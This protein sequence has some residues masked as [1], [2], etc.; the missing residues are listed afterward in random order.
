MSTDK[1][2]SESN[3]SSSFVWVGLAAIVGLLSGF[4]AG[5][6]L[7]RLRKREEPEALPPIEPAEPE[8]I[9]DIAAEP[10][11]SEPVID[12]PMP[13]RWR[14]WLLIPIAVLSWQAHLRLQD[15]DSNGF[16]WLAIA[17]VLIALAIPPISVK[18]L[19]TQHN[20]RVAGLGRQ[21]I[22]A[23][24]LAAG[25]AL[26]L[27][28]ANLFW[29]LEPGV[30]P[31]AAPWNDY[32]VGVA[33]WMAG[34]LV[35]TRSSWRWHWHPALVLLI[36]LIGL[37][38]FLRFYQFEAFPIGVWHDE[39]VNALEAR[40]MLNIPDYEP[41]F[42]PNITG[43]HL[44]LY[45][46]GLE[47]I[48]VTDISG[49]RL[50]SA[51]FGLASVIMAYAVGNQLRGPYFGLLMALMLAVM[52]WSLTF[53]RIAM[54][55]VEVGFFTL[56]TL[57]FVIRLARH[58]ELR[59]A[60]LTGLSLGLGLWFYSAFRLIG[61]PLAVFGLIAWLTWQGRTWRSLL[62]VG[63]TVAFTALVVIFPLVSYADINSE[64]FF[65]RTE[66]VSI[67][68]RIEF[69]GGIQIIGQNLEDDRSIEAT[70]EDNLIA[71]L[72]MFH[73][74]GDRNG[75][76]NLPRE[77]MLDPIT[78]ILLGLGVG[79][80]LLRGL[81]RPETWFFALLFVVTLLSGV[82]TLAFEAPQG[83]RTIGVLPALAYGAALGAWGIGAIIAQVVHGR[84]RI[85]ALS[86]GGL[87]LAGLV[88]QANYH[89]FFREQARDFRSW[90][91]YTTSS[92]LVGLM[93][94]ES[95]ARVNRIF[96]SPWLARTESMIFVWPE[97]DGIQRIEI[98][99]ALPLRIPASDPATVF[100]DN[101]ESNLL[102]FA[103]E[104][105]PEA[106]L[107]AVRPA[108]YDVVFPPDAPV[109]FFRLDLQ[110]ADIAFAQGLGAD[111]S[112]V[113][114]VPLSGQY[115]FWMDDDEVQVTLNG[116]TYSESGFEVELAKGNH[117]LHV[118][119]LS[120]LRWTPAGSVEIVPIPQHFLYHDP[121]KP[122][123]LH[124][125][126]YPNENWEGTP[127]ETRID[128]N[129]DLQIHILPLNRPYTI[130]WTGFLEIETPGN[131][132]FEVQTI[133]D[134]TVYLD[135]D[136]ILMTDEVDIPVG[137]S[138]NLDAGR[139]PIQVDM[140]DYR[141]GSGIELR[142]RTPDAPSLEVIPNEV[143]S[144]Y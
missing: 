68:Q 138:L 135:G 18:P 75:R 58:G 33:L 95:E 64:M 11:Q 24:G 35:L 16:W 84:I 81:R 27:D 70:L 88:T 122:N 143:F 123:G 17:G 44:M 28:A 100:F 119:P 9:P 60:L 94:A 5:Q 120:N 49:L 109:L 90:S 8:P 57:Y 59:D 139:Y 142:W 36:G 112:G 130:R 141:H 116:V 66:E 125:A 121:V 71:H 128:P 46:I 53:S 118:S 96:A 79:I 134:A 50:F 10:T 43:I 82:I 104:L 124:T 30:V 72:E 110:P 12:A 144:H 105:Y 69:D 127:A 133:G 67:I 111:G 103:R 38:A 87:L 34:G 22:G 86:I 140:L 40:R 47:N 115:R 77:P 51:I 83:L 74:T 137:T 61:I 93:G 91:T 2:S 7:E 89:T 52:R 42:V 85:V 117:A 1:T 129:I 3:P 25:T 99:D 92:T 98:P 56:L 106:E 29:A 126:L 13:G 23:I 37:A 54:T 65:A 131:Y 31:D 6:L 80:A 14:L 55:G 113:L 62:V 76:H 26:L 73:I 45:E 39:A 48:G 63:L 101:R 78:G 102:A 21:L 32:F 108:D 19:I 114:Y 15:Q 107:R 136:V 41:L 132:G 4:V 20:L 97:G